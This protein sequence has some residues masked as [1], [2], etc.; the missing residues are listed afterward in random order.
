[1]EIAGLNK[2]HFLNSNPNHLGVNI[3]KGDDEW[4]LRITRVLLKAIVYLP[5]NLALIEPGFHYSITRSRSLLEAIRGG[6]SQ[7]ILFLNNHRQW[8]LLINGENLTKDIDL[9][10][11]ARFDVR[12]TC[13]VNARLGILRKNHG[14]NPHK[15]YWL[16]QC[17]RF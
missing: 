2:S 11:M 17:K 7:R 14:E 1:M 13:L 15:F 9:T 8:K 12:R 6:N 5:A 4:H 10:T 3:T 16:V